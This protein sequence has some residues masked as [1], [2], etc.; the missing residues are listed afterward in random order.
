M[1]K[2]YQFN[3][4][5]VVVGILYRYIRLTPPIVF[6]VLYNASFLVDSGEGPYW[7]YFGESER[8]YCR[9]SWWT[10]LLHINNVVNTDDMVRVET[11]LGSLGTLQLFF[12]TKLVSDPHMVCR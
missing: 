6:L 4:K 8:S 5:Y 1:F 2:R 10:N 7:K 12:P 3:L 9:T 11:Q